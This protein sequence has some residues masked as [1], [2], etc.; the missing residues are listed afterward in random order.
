MRTIPLSQYIN[1]VVT[2]RDG[3]VATAED[4]L[5]KSLGLPKL[6]PILKQNLKAVCNPDKP[7]EAVM[8]LLGHQMG[9]SER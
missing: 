2:Y 8:T 6:T 7:N 1:A 5:A 4:L 9:G 3:N